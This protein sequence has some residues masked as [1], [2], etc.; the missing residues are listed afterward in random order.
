MSYTATSGLIVWIEGDKKNEWYTAYDWQYK[1]FLNAIQFG[2]MKSMGYPNPLV[3]TKPFKNGIYM[4]RFHIHNDWN[5]CYIENMT[6]K[7][8]R[9]IK[10]FELGISAHS[11]S[12]KAVI[13]KSIINPNY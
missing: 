11:Y 6:T 1:Q 8:I 7:K 10:Y 4:Y 12:D 13:K 2:T 9:E 3:K 5:P